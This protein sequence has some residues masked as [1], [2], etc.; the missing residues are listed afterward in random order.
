MKVDQDSESLV[1]AESKNNY[2]TKIGGTKKTMAQI[3][4]TPPVLS[5]ENFF[6]GK[7]Y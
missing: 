2:F 3:P 7:I 1:F 4:T 5:T 6:K